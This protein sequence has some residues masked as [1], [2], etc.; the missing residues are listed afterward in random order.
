MTSGAMSFN[1]DMHGN[2]SMT[3]GYSFA[4]G[5][6]QPSFFNPQLSEATELKIAQLQAK[7]NQK[8]GPE[9]ISQRPGPGGGPKLTYAEGWKVINL[10]NEVF[11]FNGWSSSIVNLTTDFIDFNE[12]SRRYTVGTTAIVRVTLRDG[13]FHEDIGY[14]MLENSKSKGAAIDKCKKEAVTD[15]LKRALRNFGNLMGNC[16]YDK[17]YTQEVVKM[18]VQQPKFDQSEL[19][20][21][22]EFEDRKPNVASTSASASSSS[23]ANI[24]LSLLD[25]T[26]EDIKPNVASSSTT[27]T[28]S[29]RL[30]QI[31]ANLPGPSKNTH[32]VAMPPQQGQPKPVS[33]IPSHIRSEMNAAWPAHMNT[34]ERS[35]SS[36]AQ[37][38]SNDT[39]SSTAVSGR[40]PADAQSNIGMQAHRQDQNPATGNRSKDAKFAKTGNTKSPRLRANRNPGK[41]DGDESYH[42]GSEDDAFLALVDMGE[43]DMGQ[44]LLPETDLGRPLFDDDD[45][46]HGGSFFEGEE[47][48]A[49]SSLPREQ[50]GRPQAQAHTGMLS[51]LLPQNQQQQQQQ[52]QRSSA[53]CVQPGSASKQQQS[54]APNQRHPQQPPQQPQRPMNNQFGSSL[55][56]GSAS[57]SSSRLNQNGNVVQRT[58]N[59]HQNQNTNQPPAL[60]H[61][62]A[63]TTVSAGTRPPTPSTGGFHFP[64]GVDAHALSGHGSTSV[65]GVKR[66]LESTTPSSNG[67]LGGGPMQ[68]GGQ[69]KREILG[70]LDVGEGGDVKRLRR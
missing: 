32:P 57:S 23:M 7:L 24:S 35:N 64:P 40:L 15:G 65:L 62:S 10:A 33:S 19:H 61:S 14:G 58:G 30:A 2:Q 6:T 63:T 45:E 42:F 55:K 66:P 70:R 69:A 16:L 46:G 31:S 39:G 34:S 68:G 67:K 12:E 17:S 37:T 27:T 11:G 38:T 48:Q 50:T 47:A 21:R 60:G 8:L 20:R 1:A 52:P 44:P 22:P 26:S 36:S 59:Y 53:N 54:H 18:K 4:L 41:E 49:R 56:T 5:S 13:V 51:T 9:Y 29:S 28:P 3:E 43:G 25:Q